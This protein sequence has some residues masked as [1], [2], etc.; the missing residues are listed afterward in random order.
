VAKN[1]LTK[2]AQALNCLARNLSIERP[3]TA[4]CPAVVTG[5]LAAFRMGQIVIDFVIS[6]VSPMAA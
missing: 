1:R 6:T 4:T 3:G 5:G 2:N